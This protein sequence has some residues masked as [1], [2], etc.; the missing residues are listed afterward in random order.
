MALDAYEVELIKWHRNQLRSESKKFLKLAEIFDGTYTSRQIGIAVPKEFSEFQGNLNYCRRLTTI[1]ADRQQVRRFSLPGQEQADPV[2]KEIMAASN[3]SAQFYMFNINRMVSGVGILSVNTNGPGGSPLIRAESPTQVHVAVDELTEQTSSAARFL[4]KSRRP[5]QKG[6]EQIA[7]LYLPNETITAVL[8]KNGWEEHSERVV[9]NLGRVPVV[10]HFNHRLT[11][12][13][14]GRSEFADL[15]DIQ[16]AAN[17]AWLLMQLVNESHGWPGKWAAVKAADQ[18][19]KNRTKLEAYTDSF[20]LLNDETAKV[21]QFTAA[22]L[23]NFSQAFE[24]IDHKAAVISGLP[25]KYLQKNPAMPATEGAIIADE[26]DLVRNIE[27][28]NEQ[29]GVPLGAIGAIAYELATNTK[30]DKPLSVEW[31]NPATPTIAQRAD[32]LSKQVAVGALSVEGFWDELDWSE[33]RKAKER[34]NLAAQ[35]AGQVNPVQTYLAGA[36]EPLEV[37]LLDMPP[38]PAVIGA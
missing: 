29:L 5:G 23:K 8:T 6:D 18:M 11:G 19:L 9:H 34:A 24:E 30:L 37:P 26:I 17:R 32:A 36:S 12:E 1:K 38:D 3:F 35:R 2:M 15:I 14:K 28:A 10:A 20:F 31:F 22:D 16:D 21:G 7:V 25:A 4:V 33:A 27:S 13:W